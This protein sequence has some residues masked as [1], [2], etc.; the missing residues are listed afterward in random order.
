MTDRIA[1]QVRAIGESSVL[2]ASELGEKRRNADAVAAPLNGLKADGD[3]R[4]VLE[5]I[6]WI[7]VRQPVD[8][9]AIR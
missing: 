5:R 4:P 6:S 1:D 9:I 7:V 3:E 8:P 2:A